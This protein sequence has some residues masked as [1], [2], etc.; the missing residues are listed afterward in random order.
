[1]SADSHFVPTPIAAF[2]LR[3]QRA[4]GA[5][6]QLRR[7]RED[8]RPLRS[9]ARSYALA[10]GVGALP[11]YNGESATGWVAQMVIKEHNQ[12]VH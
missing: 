6:R 12:P 4:Q 7:A 5:P 10:R 11:S 1:M 9:R 2:L 8:L 3:A